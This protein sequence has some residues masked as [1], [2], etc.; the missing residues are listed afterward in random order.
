MRRPRT[1]RWICTN[2]V[3]IGALDHTTRVSDIGERILNNVLPESGQE[4]QHFAWL[5]VYQWLKEFSAFFESLAVDQQ[6]KPDR[7]ACFR[8]VPGPYA[9][10]WLSAL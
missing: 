8:A 7:K 10:S 1:N 9:G 6:P 5:V 2:P 3:P 4:Y